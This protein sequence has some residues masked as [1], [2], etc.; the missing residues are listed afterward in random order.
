MTKIVGIL[1]LNTLPILQVMNCLENNMPEFGGL[2]KWDI[3]SLDGNP[4]YHRCFFG[5][6]RSKLEHA[7]DL[8]IPSLK[9]NK[10]LRNK[11]M[12]EFGGI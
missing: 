3:L 10:T 2:K 7:I 8:N 6:F 12:P 9:V 5:R 4:S 11:N 1:K